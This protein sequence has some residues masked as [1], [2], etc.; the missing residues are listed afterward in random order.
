MNQVFASTP[1]DSPV[2]GSQTSR[3][4]ST[5]QPGREQVDSTVLLERY[6][7]Y[8]HRSI[9]LLGRRWTG[10]VLLAMHDGVERFSEIRDAV[11]GLSDRLLVERL[12]ELQTEQIVERVAHGSDIQYR[13]T[14]KGRDLR[15]VLEALAAWTQQHC[16]PTPHAHPAD[17]EHEHEHE[18]EPDPV[19][20]TSDLRR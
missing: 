19:L 7:P 3:T 11:P 16:A 6:C 14:A 13:L 5:N 9:E 4:G 20:R 17:H 1:P 15:P 8:F 10:V 12:R 18:T 2:I